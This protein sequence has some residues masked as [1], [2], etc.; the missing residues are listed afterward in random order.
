VRREIGM[1]E[2]RKT[3]GYTAVML[4]CDQICFTIHEQFSR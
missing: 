2:C 1:E 4:R 3:L